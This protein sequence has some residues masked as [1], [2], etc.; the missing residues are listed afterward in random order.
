MSSL[1][2]DLPTAPFLHLCGFFSVGEVAKLGILNRQMYHKSRNDKIWEKI[3]AQQLPSISN[4]DSEKPFH[5][6]LSIASFQRLCGSY[7]ADVKD[8]KEGSISG[9]LYILPS[10]CESAVI[11]TRLKEHAPKSKLW[12]L[13]SLIHLNRTLSK[14]E[15]YLQRSSVQVDHKIIVIIEIQSLEFANLIRKM[16]K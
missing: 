9:N 12:H 6:Y 5:F 8:D 13:F 11:S 14:T 7:F 1:L 4:R 3:C 15:N 16:E 2:E 10:Y